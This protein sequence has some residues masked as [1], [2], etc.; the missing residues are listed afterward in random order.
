MNSPQVNHCC[1]VWLSVRDSVGHLM[2]LKIL[3]KK[4]SSFS[5]SVIDIGSMILTKLLFRSIVVVWLS[6]ML[7]TLFFS[8]LP[9]YNIYVVLKI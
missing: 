7:S 4:D 5:S 9:Y 8:I 6:F 2:K 1:A 3:K